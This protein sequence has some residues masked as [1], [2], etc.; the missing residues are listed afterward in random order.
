MIQ[1][2]FEV[3]PASRKWAAHGPQPMISGVIGIVSN[4]SGFSHTLSGNFFDK[5]LSTC[6]NN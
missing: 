3:F 2:S 6:L 5:Q 4:L 1:Q